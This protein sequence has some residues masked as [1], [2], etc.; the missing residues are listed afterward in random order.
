MEIITHKNGNRVDLEI[1]GDVDSWGSDRLRQ[2][3][4]ESV[5]N[6]SSEVAIDLAAVTHLGSSG[7]LTLLEFQKDLD[8]LGG[9]LVVRNAGEKIKKIF[10]ALKINLDQLTD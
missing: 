2:V 6:G 4:M 3:I 5:R 7:L 8:S 10:H 9:R 1:L